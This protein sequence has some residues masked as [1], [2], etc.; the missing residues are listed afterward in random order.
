MV[1]VRHTKEELKE[2]QRYPLDM[3]IMLTKDRIRGFYNEFGGDVYVSRSG[4]KDSDV[5]GHIVKGMYPDVPHVFVDTG[6]EWTS[7]QKHGREVADRVLYPQMNF[8]QTI[9]RYGYPVISKEVAQKVEDARRKPDGKCAERFHDCEHNRRYP[10]HSMER[11]AWLLDAPFKI[12]HKCC[13]VNKKRPAKAYEKES[14]RKALLA[15]MAEESQ[16]RT[17][18]WLRD[19]CNAFNAKRPVSAPLSFWTE[20]DILEYIRRYNIKIA[21]VYGEI[22]SGDG[23]Y[24]YYP[25]PGMP[26]PL[27]TS[28]CRRTGCVWC[29]F[30]ISHDAEK[31]LRLKK[32]EP[33]KYSYVMGGGQ[34]IGSLWTPSKDGLGYRYVLDWLNEHGGM[35]I[36]Y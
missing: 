22:V 33:K 12:S 31:F 20:Q 5:L 27:M 24:E 30:G 8:R 11:Y 21:D 9:E 34:F 29:C 23:Q 36:R 28:G 25:M 3:K 1:D 19:G 4:G 15:T 32:L 16:L 18:K 7:V 26:C 10:Q 14:G 6:L 35:Q 13:E 2:M 17:T